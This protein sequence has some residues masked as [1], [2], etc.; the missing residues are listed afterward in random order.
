MKLD[1]EIAHQHCFTH[2]HTHIYIYINQQ[3]NSSLQNGDSAILGH[4]IR[5]ILSSKS[6]F[7]Y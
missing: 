7:K 3:I 2:T 5:Q 6:V 1:T 4:H